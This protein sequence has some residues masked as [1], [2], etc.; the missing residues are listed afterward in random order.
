MYSLVTARAATSVPSRV[1]VI[2]VGHREAIIVQLPQFGLN[3]LCIRATMAAGL[4]LVGS[5][6]SCILAM[7]AVYGMTDACAGRQ[8]AKLR[9]SS[10]L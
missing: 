9:S 7:R 6:C 8:N 2:G 10:A 5:F 1:V 4:C 3:V